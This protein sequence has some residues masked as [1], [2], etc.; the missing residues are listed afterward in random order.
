MEWEFAGDEGDFSEV[1]VTDGKMIMSGVYDGFALTTRGVA[2]IIVLATLALVMTFV[3]LIFVDGLCKAFRDCQ[4]PFEEVVI[5]KMQYF[6][7]SLIPWTL[8]TTV[9]NSITDT[10]VNQKFSISFTINLGVVIIVLAFIILVNIFKYGAVLQQE[11]DET[12]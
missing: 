8:V 5:K 2:A 12:L 4:S 3:T 11:S 6:A 9:S 10:I 1:N 7:Y